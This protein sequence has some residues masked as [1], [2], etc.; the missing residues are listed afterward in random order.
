MDPAISSSHRPLL[1]SFCPLDPLEDGASCQYVDLAS[2]PERH[3]GYSGR[4]ATRVWQKIYDELCFHPERDLKT[5]DLTA[6]NMKSM[7]FEKR[8]FYRVVS[9]LHASI[10][11]HI[12]SHYSLG[13]GTWGRNDE[14]FGRRFSPATTDGEGPER[15][16]NLY[17]LYLLELRALV[18]AAPV[19]QQLQFGSGD[20]EEDARMRTA[21]SA[22]LQRARGST[23]SLAPSACPPWPG[24]AAAHCSI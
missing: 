12:S 11:V 3:T 1:N 18:K 10:S 6:E 2:N 13:Q 8:A 9:G 17:F 4:A 14:E 21:L 16:Q 20:A 15:L 22:L 24:R 23:N 7:C 19:L 5:F